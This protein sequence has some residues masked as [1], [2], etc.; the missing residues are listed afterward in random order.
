MVYYCT[1]DADVLVKSGFNGNGCGNRR[2]NTLLCTLLQWWAKVDFT[3]AC[4]Y[5]DAERNTA[6]SNEHHRLDSDKDFMRNLH[7]CCEKVKI[8]KYQRRAYM[9]ARW[10]HWAVVLNS[11]DTYYEHNMEAKADA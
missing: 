1:G 7:L 10:F 2:W 8:V 11:Y 5:H 9:I 3:M 4:R 6:F